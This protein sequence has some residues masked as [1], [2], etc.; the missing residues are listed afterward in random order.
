KVVFEIHLSCSAQVMTPSSPAA[1]CLSSAVRFAMFWNAS[2]T[3]AAVRASP[4][5][6]TTTGVTN[7]GVSVRSVG[8]ALHH[9]WPDGGH[10]VVPRAVVP[11]SVRPPVV[12][13]REQH[14][15]AFADRV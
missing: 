15:D 8:I 7:S 13:S 6:G 5:V 4:A 12:V 2:F 9:S 10:R 1:V 14:S 3:L 11:R